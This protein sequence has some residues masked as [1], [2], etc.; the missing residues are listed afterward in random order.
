MS[1]RSEHTAP[2]TAPPITASPTT[3]SGD[4]GPGTREQS[5][6]LRLLPGRSATRPGW[7]LDQ[8]T[9]DLGRQ[10]VAQAREILRHHRPPEPAPVRKAS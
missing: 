3:A 9:R 6:Q 4:G 7:Y 1:E 5:V 10:G 2:T 8:R